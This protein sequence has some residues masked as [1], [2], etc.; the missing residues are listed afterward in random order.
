M[1]T[2]GLPVVTPLPIEPAKD[3]AF[4]NRNGNILK[5]GVGR[6]DGLFCFQK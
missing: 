4:W 1:L 6:M 2:Y 3:G 5:I